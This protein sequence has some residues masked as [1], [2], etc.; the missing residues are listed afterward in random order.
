M[1]KK[2]RKSGLHEWESWNREEGR[3][4]NQELSCAGN[5]DDRKEVTDE[6]VW[7]FPVGGGGG[8]QHAGDDEEMINE[9]RE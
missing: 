7:G 2:K 3:V 1:E 5:R 6:W 8:G 9:W 4:E